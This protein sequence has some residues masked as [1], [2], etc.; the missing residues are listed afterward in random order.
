VIKSQPVDLPYKI[1]VTY[2]KINGSGSLFLVTMPNNGI[3]DVFIQAAS[4][5]IGFPAVP[6]IVNARCQ[7]GITPSS[8]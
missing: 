1:L 5:G 8:P 6:E 7:G 2:R 4:D 3:T